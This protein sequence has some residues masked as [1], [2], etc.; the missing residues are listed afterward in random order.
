MPTDHVYDVT[1][2]GAGPSGLAAAVYASSE[3]LSTMVVEQHAVGGQAGT[4]SLIRN[5]PGFARGVS[6]A[7]LAW[8]S[9]QQAWSF[10]SEYSFLRQ[11]DAVGTDGD[12]R[13]VSMSDGSVVRTR[14]VVIA[15]GVDYRML[16]VPSLERLVGR[17]VF[18]GAAVSEAPSMAGT[19]VYV[20]GGGNS[21]G[22]AALH[23]ARY[24]RQVTLLV[25]GPSLAASMSEYLI[26]QLEATRN[27]AIRYRTAVMGGH[28]EDGCLA[29]LTLGRP[30]G[31]DPHGD[32]AVEEV[33]ASGLFVL[34]GSVPRTSWLPAEVA[35]DEAGFIRTGQDGRLLLETSM[36]GVF[37]VGDVR[38]G[39][40]KRVATAVGDGATVI[41]LLHGY[42]AAH[43]VTSA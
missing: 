30:G 12:L 18:Y 1:V 5:Y 32:G 25:R 29:G 33:P 35:R 28:E 2:I 3:G 11:V 17:G 24:A 36:E 22:Q 43:P 38:S 23:L 27:V 41:A 13:T 19:E 8:R 42:L 14:S 40:I 39:S 4:S 10:G 31:G 37:A 6:G 15:T 16:D 9:F 7:H 21:A 26:S 34:I 20:V